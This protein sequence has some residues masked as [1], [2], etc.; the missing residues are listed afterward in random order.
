ME[1]LPTE[2]QKLQ[3]SCNS[4]ILSAIVS[5]VKHSKVDKVVMCYPTVDPTGP[6]AAI[7]V[8]FVHST[9]QIQTKKVLQVNYKWQ[10]K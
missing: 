4:A 2:K 7:P 6:T 1:T 9:Q 10:Q 8:A 5:Y 3:I